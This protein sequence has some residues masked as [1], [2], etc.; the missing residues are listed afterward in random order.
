MPVQRLGRE[1]TKLMSTTTLS[2]SSLRKR[3]APHPRASP[4]PPVSSSLWHSKATS[5]GSQGSSA[6]QTITVVSWR[7]RRR[8]QLC[9]SARQR[10]SFPS[11]KSLNGGGGELQGTVTTPSRTIRWMDCSCCY[12]FCST[13]C[14]KRQKDSVWRVAEA[15]FKSLRAVCLIHQISLLLLLFLENKK[16]FSFL[17]LLRSSKR[18]RLRL[19]SCSLKFLFFFYC[20]SKEQKEFSFDRAFLFSFF[21]SYLKEEKDW[22]SSLH[23]FFASFEMARWESNLLC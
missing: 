7:R 20:F 14:L 9:G 3:L 6:C 23:G 16:D 11:S 5:Q 15:P 2:S 8:R 17:L 13:V 4:P 22:F 12:R 19:A 21:S 1:D 10:I 18:K